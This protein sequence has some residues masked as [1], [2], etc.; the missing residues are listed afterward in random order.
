VC[1]ELNFVSLQIEHAF[2]VFVA[3]LVP[4]RAKILTP[5]G[6]HTHLAAH[7]LYI[8]MGASLPRVEN[9]ESSR[10]MALLK[11]FLSCKYSTLFVCTQM[12][13]EESYLL[14]NFTGG[15]LNKTLAEFGNRLGTIIQVFSSCSLS[16]SGSVLSFILLANVLSNVVLDCNR[17]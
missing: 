17:T 1:C 14:F 8:T 7:G 5:V 13:T 6:L 11:R 15:K 16:K 2:T 4:A 10:S 12:L 3:R 9:P